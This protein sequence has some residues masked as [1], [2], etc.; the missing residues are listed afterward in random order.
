VPA[1]ALRVLHL[2]IRGDEAGASAA[3]AAARVKIDATQD[4]PWRMLAARL[5][6]KKPAGILP[7]SPDDW[8]SILLR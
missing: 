3:L 1:E 8:M 2:Y 4:G 7:A 5:E 6:K